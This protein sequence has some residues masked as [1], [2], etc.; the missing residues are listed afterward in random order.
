MK[1]LLLLALCCLP[2]SV[3]G[4]TLTITNVQAEPRQIDAAAG[5]QVA[6]RFTLSAAADVTVRIYDGRDLLIRELS[7]PGLAAGGHTVTWD[8]R[9]QEGRSVPPEAYI[10]TLTADRRGERV[11]FDLSDATGGRDVVPR[12]VKWDAASGTLS[13]VLD[14][15][16]RVNV[17]IGLQNNGPLL[18]TL[19]NWVVRPG[20]LQQERWDGRDAS[21]VLDL[22]RHPSLDVFVQAFALPDNAILVGDPQ[23]AVE[24]IEPL[25]WKRDARPRSAAPPKRMYAHAQQPLEARGDVTVKLVLPSG[26]A[27]TPEGLPIVSG[28]P[29]PVRLEI[30]ERDRERTLATR[31]EPVFFVDGQFMFENEVGF[32]PMTWTWDATNVNDGEHVLTVN[33]R[34]YEG[35]FGIA[36][37]KVVKRSAAQ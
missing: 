33:V 7:R 11:V 2:P 5:G 28:G 6:I 21:G 18:R 36:S 15:P 4:Q 3:L 1:R 25:Q 16:A 20:G 22:A 26:L 27:T 12:A 19:I 13:Y 8:G 34:G 9:D 24:L 37:V 14:A 30:D 32:A 17:R 23:Q 31:F 35:N 29:V 10:Y